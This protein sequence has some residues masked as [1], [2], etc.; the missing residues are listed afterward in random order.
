MAAVITRNDE[1]ARERTLSVAPPD[2]EDEFSVSRVT[3][4]LKGLNF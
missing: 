1:I 3:L 2:G 4:I